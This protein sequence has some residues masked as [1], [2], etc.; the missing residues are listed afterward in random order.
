MI[1]TCFNTDL[2]IKDV[3]RE[4]TLVGWAAKRR[5]LGQLLFIDL[6]DRS[7][8]IQVLVTDTTNVPDIRNEY[9]IEVKG[10]VNK[11][12][13]PNKNLKTGEIEILAKEVNVINKAKNPR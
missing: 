9:V 4:V 6:R 12:E 8:I 13:V 1:R 11:K 2:T 5:N 7:G 10:V 3:G